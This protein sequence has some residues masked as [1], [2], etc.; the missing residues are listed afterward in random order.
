MSVS[1]VIKQN[2]AL[3]G[4]VP[5]FSNPQHVGRP[6]LAPRESLMVRLNDILDRRWLSNDGKY[7]QEF[8]RRLAELSETDHAIVYSNATV[9]LEWL[10][11]AMN[12]TGEIIV[13]AF[14]FVASAHAVVPAGCTP[15]LA[16]VDPDTHLLDP[17]SVR[18]LI[19]PQT[20]AIMGVHLWGQAAP[21]EEIQAIADEQQLS[22]IYDAAH[23]LGATCRG[24]PIGSYGDASVYSF[25]ATKFVNSLEGGAIVT[26]DDALAA[27]LRQVRNFGFRGYDNVEMVG[28]NGKMDEFRAA[29]G[30]GSL[31]AMEEFITINRRNW[32]LYTEG[33]A[34]TP[35]IQVYQYP[36]NERL[37]Y[38]YAVLSVTAECPLRRNELLNVLW[39]EN[40]QARRYFFPGLHRMEP[41]CSTPGHIRCP[42]PGTE[43]ASQQVLVLPTGQSMQPDDVMQVVQI[44]KAAIANFAQVR[45]ALKTT[46]LPKHPRHERE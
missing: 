39:T 40:V 9:A 5:K 43:L 46:T 23:A 25:H 41:Y 7:L 37:N 28:T 27:R 13:P 24:K 38:Q 8:E 10:V 42:L 31:D 19:T 21:I 44:I 3:L 11:R 36:A 22:V 20:S 33:L 15:V 29:V 34:G 26:N 32:Q 14:T 12:L 30:I 17:A 2:L 4:G 35:G 6:N 1:S 16:D 18:K 45:D